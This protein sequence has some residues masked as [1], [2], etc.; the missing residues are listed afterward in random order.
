M[1]RAGLFLSPEKKFDR[2]SDF[3]ASWLGAIGESGSWALEGVAT[4]APNH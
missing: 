4:L 3:I 2:E 1:K